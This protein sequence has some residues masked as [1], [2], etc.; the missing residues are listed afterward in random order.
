MKNRG[1][2]LIFSIFIIT[3]FIV[4]MTV[5]ATIVFNSASAIS[6]QKDYQA[7]YYLAEAGIEYG[8]AQLNNNPGWCTPGITL[9]VKEGSFEVKKE[10]G[11]EILY[12]NGY[13]GR[14]H[15]IIRADVI[16]HTS[17]LQREE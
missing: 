4:I 10:A 2:T 6:G 17:Y 13:S 15:V 11:K 14:A 8:K 1:F 3:V 5:A 16:N 9:K 12:S 7:A